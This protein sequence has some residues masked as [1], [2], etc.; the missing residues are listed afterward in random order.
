VAT[1]HPPL[2]QVVLLGLTAVLLLC[3][4]K[5]GAFRAW[6]LSLP[7]RMLLLPH[8]LRFVGVYFLVLHERGELPYAFAVPGGRG[9]IV[10]AMGA[11]VLWFLPG[12][13]ERRKKAVLAW[14]IF[15][16]IDILFVVV[17]AARL[18]FADPHSM[19]ALLRLPLSMLP[20]FVVPIIIASHVMIFVRVR[21]AGTEVQKVS[22]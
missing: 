14:N 13:L 3:F 4:W 15:G 9:D 19:A 18:A 20:T 10:T 7:L 6:V 21:R 8:F 2:P 1:L 5:A 17:T 11:V 16:F 22:V 12:P